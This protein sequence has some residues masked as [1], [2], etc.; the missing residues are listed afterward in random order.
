MST[1]FFLFRELLGSIRARS[2]TLFSAAS[3][4]VFVCLASFAALLLVGGVPNER[5]D[6]FLDE[7]EIEVHLSPR[8]SAEAVNDLYLE[9]RDRPDVASI[10]FRFAQEVSPGSSGGRF[11]VRTA[12][13]DATQGVLS[14]VEL[15]SGITLAEAG[16]A[17]PSPGGFSLPSTARIGLLAALVLSVALS[18]VLAR[19]GFRVLLGTFHGEIRVMRLAGAPERTIV[20]PVVALGILMGLLAGLLLVVG[21][22][23]AQYALGEGSHAVSELANSGRVLSVSFTGLILGLLLGSLIGLFGASLLSSREFSPLP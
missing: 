2:A 11:F 16:T 4:F 12:S 14:A 10:S 7:D 23:L 9:I 17:A 18:L 1:F 3:L 21:I 15:M 5:G 6:A 22:Y 13:A 20:P 19:G 8:L